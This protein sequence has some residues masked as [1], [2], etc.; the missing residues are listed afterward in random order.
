MVSM[1]N[2]VTYSYLRFETVDYAPE[3]MT[4][5]TACR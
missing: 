5:E 1:F 2:P 4:V 3:P